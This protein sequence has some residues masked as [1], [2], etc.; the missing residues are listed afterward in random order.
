M[1]EV[2]PLDTQILWRLKE[3]L[4]KFHLIQGFGP[5]E[6]KKFHT[7]AHTFTTSLGEQMIVYF[8][9]LLKPDHHPPL[10]TQDFVTESLIDIQSID[11]LE[12]QFE[13]E[14]EVQSLNFRPKYHQ[15]GVRERVL[16]DPIRLLIWIIIGIYYDG[17]IGQRMSISVS[18]GLLVANGS[19]R[20]FALVS[21]SFV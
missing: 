8:G 10:Q 4:L 15:M 9:R 19:V 12:I 14:N 6:A 2:C 1:C 13:I 7:F 5:T 3:V 18:L 17:K 16:I 11:L 21:F 20:W